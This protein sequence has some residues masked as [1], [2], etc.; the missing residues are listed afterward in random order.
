MTR[1]RPPRHASAHRALARGL[2]DW[3]GAGPVVRRPASPGSSISDPGG[4]IG[5]LGY[6]VRRAGASSSARFI[7]SCYHV[8]ASAG[9]GPGTPI[10]Q[11]AGGSLDTDHIADFFDGDPPVASS[12]FDNLI[13]AGI[14]EL[15]DPDDVSELIP[16]IGR[17]GGF[18]T[19][20]SEGMPVHIVGASTS[21]F[22]GRVRDPGHA[23]RMNVTM[24]D[25]T[26][27]SVGYRDTVLCEPYAARG[28]SG[29]V[30]L[31]DANDIVGLHFWGTSHSSVFC[32]IEHVID[33]LGIRMP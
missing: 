28:D 4:D 17:P 33:R 14:A 10:L 23:F 11:P 21:G 15:L 16:G 31:N 1:G 27:A 9:G 29:S 7:L 6:V 20:V 13:D 26:V 18:S 2:S 5:T 32:K 8:L 25:G 3:A 22:V 12:G 30:V 19:L 24:P